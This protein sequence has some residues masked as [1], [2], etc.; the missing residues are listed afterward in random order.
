MQSKRRILFLCAGNTCRS[1]MAEYIARSRF[2]N[3]D[4]CSAGLRPQASSDAENAIFTLRDR[5]HIDAS[6][7]QPRGIE[8][9][10]LL[11]ISLVITMNNQIA[12]KFLNKIQDYPRDQLIIWKISDPFGNDLSEYAKCAISINNSLTKLKVTYG[13]IS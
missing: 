13:W 4:F 9:I 3:I 12:N 1:V 6:A 8:K 5:F 7:H 11:K 2:G 10:D